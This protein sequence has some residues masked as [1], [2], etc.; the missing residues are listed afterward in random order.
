MNHWPW[1]VD[2]TNVGGD[3]TSKLNL[4]WFDR[5]ISLIK[6]EYLQTSKPVQENKFFCKSHHFQDNNICWKFSRNR[7]IGFILKVAGFTKKLFSLELASKFADIQI[8]L[9]KFFCQST[10]KIQFRS[11]DPAYVRTVH[12]QFRLTVFLQIFDYFQ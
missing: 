5:K 10:L 9:M 11:W 12:A 6:S 4:Q 2:C 8:L 7:K 1:T 3:P